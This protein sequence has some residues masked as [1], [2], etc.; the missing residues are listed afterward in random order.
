MHQS[1]KAFFL[2]FFLLASSCGQRSIGDGK[3][4]SLIQVPIQDGNY[5]IVF[6][7]LN[8]SIAGNFRGEGDLL[9]ENNKL[10][11]SIDVFESPVET[12]HFQ[13]LY[14]FERCP[15]LRDDLN[16]DGFIDDY[17]INK[18]MGLP[19]FPLDGDLTEQNRGYEIVP[20]SDGQGKY[21][22]EAS[23][24]LFSLY[25]DILLPD[26]NSSD[27]FKKLNSLFDFTFKKSIVLIYGLHPT[28][29][30]PGSIR[31]MGILGDRE[32]FPIACGQFVKSS[33]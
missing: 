28:T 20:A 9:L 31:S 6:E 4:L 29:Y 25:K 21:Q 26:S 15:D 5:E 8:E 23:V 1:F 10:M 16:H 12:I 32:S 22:Y 2:F 14:T 17:E 11:L 13:H 19:L 33:P 7:G 18:K 24:N 27:G 30:L 3:T